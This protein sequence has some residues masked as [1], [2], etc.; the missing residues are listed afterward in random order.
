MAENLRGKLRFKHDV[1]LP[2]RQERIRPTEWV[3]FG[4]M[5]T[6]HRLAKACCTEMGF[7]CVPERNP[8][9][10]R[11]TLRSLPSWASSEVKHAECAHHGR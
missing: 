1:P 6:E 5:L 7:P 4:I 8:W 10:R 3:L 2:G 11:R 9:W